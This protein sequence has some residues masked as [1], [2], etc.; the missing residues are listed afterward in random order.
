M[1]N[2]LLY[3]CSAARLNFS[4]SKILRSPNG[5]DTEMAVFD[6]KSL[7][8]LTRKKKGK[9]REQDIRLRLMETIVNRRSNRSKRHWQVSVVLP[10]DLVSLCQKQSLENAYF[11]PPPFHSYFSKQT[12]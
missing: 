7:R 12:I 9:A 3:F 4:K 5:I 6:F 8:A 1:I 2:K 10:F 11:R